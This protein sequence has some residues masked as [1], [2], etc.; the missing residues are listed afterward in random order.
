MKKILLIVVLLF[1]YGINAQVVIGDNMVSNQNI[2]KVKD[3][4]RGV[5]LPYSTTF[6][7]FP[8]YD[9]ASSDLFSDYPNLVGGLIYNKA[10]DQYYKYDGFAWNPARQI[11]G[12]FQPKGSRLGISSGITIPCLAFGLGIC[13]S[14]GAPVYLAPDNKSQVLVD[15]LLLKNASSVTVKQNGMYDIAAALG[16]TGG[17]VGAQLGVTEFKLTLQVKYTPASDWE[18]IVT[19]TNYSLVFI[20]DTQ[21]SK[22]SSFAQTVSLP[23][24][25][26]LRVVPTI[27]TVGGSGGSLSAYGTDSNSINS[28]IGAR[29][30]KAY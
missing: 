3:G 19:K 21:G 1:Q 24:G 5:I 27:T 26:E 12:I 28:Y 17:S 15:N 29:L 10:D 30:I 6:T 11:Q 9:A 13:L 16:F 4:T 25:A 20:I 14:L 23:A 7:A 22:T 8:K 18:T 2:V